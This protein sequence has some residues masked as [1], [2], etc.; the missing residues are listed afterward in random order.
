MDSRMVITVLLFW[1]SNID[2]DWQPVVAYKYQKTDIDIC[3]QK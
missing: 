3:K 1:S 2:M